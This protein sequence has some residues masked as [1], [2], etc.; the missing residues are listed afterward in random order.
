MD[1]RDTAK[2]KG[3]QYVK[4]ILQTPGFVFA[5]M[6]GRSIGMDR[7]RR[8]EKIQHAY[9]MMTGAENKTNLKP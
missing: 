9:Q 1:G 5:S 2:D 8:W 4:E 7:D 3:V 6:Q